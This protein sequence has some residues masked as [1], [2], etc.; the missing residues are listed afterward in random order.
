[1]KIIRTLALVSVIG[2]VSPALIWAQAA[3]PSTPP[4]QE[5]P[6]EREL[7][8]EAKG[9]VQRQREE[10]RALRKKHMEERRALQQKLMQERG[11][12]GTTSGPPEGSL[13]R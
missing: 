3:A 11:D 10:M 8:P 12:R 9:L 13:Q 7:P 6:T 2:F 1:M 4:S 5:R